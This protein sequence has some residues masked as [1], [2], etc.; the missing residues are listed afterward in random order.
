MK[1]LI[2]ALVITAPLFTAAQSSQNYGTGY[3]QQRIKYMMDVNLDVNTNKITGKQTISYTNNSPDTLG[4]IFVHLYWNAFH[5][6]PHP[7]V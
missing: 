3:W 5:A 2:I 7:D 4:K 1:N 6:T